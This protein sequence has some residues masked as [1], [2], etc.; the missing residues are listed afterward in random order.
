MNYIFDLDG[1]LINSKR[2]HIEVLKDVL[3]KYRIAADNRLYSQ[4]M[5]FKENG[6]T[7]K[8][9]LCDI[10]GESEKSGLLMSQEWVAL[11]E[12]E[13]YM[14]FDTLYTE[15]Y[16]VL[17]R[18]SG[19]HGKIFFL[20]ARNNSNATIKELSDMGIAKFA[21]AVYIVPS[22]EN[23]KNKVNLVN[24][25]CKQ[26]ETCIFVGDTEADL[27]AA[28]ENDIP[29]IMLNRGFRC[30]EYWNRNGIISHSTM[31]EG[32]ISLGVFIERT[33]INGA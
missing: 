10:M 25:I 18:L 20:T 2:R 31:T 26:G 14:R 28:L 3:N 11:I 27:E 33:G 1:T 9:F 21:E 13:K 32:F 12:Q 17:E 5:N 19:N 4:Y 15:S 16:H 29:Y 8:R 30:R 23:M 6:G 22:N 24:K 7:T